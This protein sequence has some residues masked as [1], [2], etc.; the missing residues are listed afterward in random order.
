MS[1]G[2]QPGDINMD[3]PEAEEDDDEEDDDME[4]VS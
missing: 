4:E 3:S 1:I 2:S